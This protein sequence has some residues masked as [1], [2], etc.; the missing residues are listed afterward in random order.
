MS[1]IYESPDGGKTVYSREFGEQERIQESIN[2]EV[3]EA[4]DHIRNE[5]LW[6]N[7]YTEAK[8]NVAL[9]NALDQVILIYKLSREY[10]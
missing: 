3:V 7:I 2:N 5:L 8:T 9:Q 4:I 1:K 6:N 10:K